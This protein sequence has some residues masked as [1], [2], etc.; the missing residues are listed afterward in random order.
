MKIL[1][2]AVVTSYVLH[3]DYLLN[4]ETVLMQVVVM[5]RKVD[6]GEVSC[7]LRRQ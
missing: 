1:Y 7:V 2:E 3:I 4:T 6:S 5:G